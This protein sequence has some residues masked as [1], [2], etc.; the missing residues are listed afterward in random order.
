MKKILILALISIPLIWGYKKQLGMNTFYPQTGIVKNVDYEN[1]LVT[2]EDFNGNIWEFSECEDWMEGDIVSAIMYNN[3][4][5]K[6]I[7]DDKIVSLKY[8]GYVE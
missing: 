2:F 3:L 6:S 7:Y 1:N 8:S 4:T 5:K